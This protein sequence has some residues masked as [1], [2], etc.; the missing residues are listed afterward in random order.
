MATRHHEAQMQTCCGWYKGEEGW[1]VTNVV[2]VMSFMLSKVW[3]CVSETLE[4]RSQNKGPVKT[5]RLCKTLFQDT[6]DVLSRSIG[7]LPR[8][9]RT[10]NPLGHTVVLVQPPTRMQ[11]QHRNILQSCLHLHWSW[12]QLHKLALVAQKGLWRTKDLKWN[13]NR[14]R[15]A[16]A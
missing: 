6:W 3:P 9:T 12:M 13:W 11:C 7:L 8:S 10:F 4:S 15:R 1:I 5:E 16:S 14:S 2:R